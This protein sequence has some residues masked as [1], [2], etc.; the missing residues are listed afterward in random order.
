MSLQNL[1][2]K[3]EKQV[4]SLQQTLNKYFINGK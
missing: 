2:N 4:K 3:N 1:N